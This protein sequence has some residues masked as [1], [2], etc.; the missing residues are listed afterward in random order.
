MREALEELRDDRIDAPVRLGPSALVERSV[1]ALAGEPAQVGAL[2]V[3]EGDQQPLGRREH[4]VH[5]DDVRVQADDEAEGRLCRERHLRV[6]EV[7]GRQPVRLDRLER[8]RGAAVGRDRLVD[9]AERA[10]AEDRFDFVQLVA[11][12]HDR[13]ARPVLGRGRRLGRRV[14]GRRLVDHAARHDEHRAAPALSKIDFIEDSMRATCK[15]AG[16]AGVV[17][18]AAPA[19]ARLGGA[20]ASARARAL[21]PAFLNRATSSRASLMR[22]GGFCLPRAD[23]GCLRV[24]NSLSSRPS[25][26]SCTATTPRPSNRSHCSE[27]RLVHLEVHLRVVRVG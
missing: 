10:F 5:R 8:E 26:A 15:S 19:P 17:G 20:A 4:P 24:S 27:A 25:N 11:A 16:G 6:S 13:V 2:D 12:V 21:R 7:L 1:V 23:R 3:V 9:R 22:G 18:P 14:G